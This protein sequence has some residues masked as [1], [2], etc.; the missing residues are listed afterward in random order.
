[1][2]LD[3]EARG[4]TPV[5]LKVAPGKHQLVVVGE[6]QKVLKREV[7]VKAGGRLALALELARLPSE[8]SGHAGL[9]VRCRTQ[10]ELRI[11]VD[12]VDTG[13]SC[14]NDERI[15]IAPG[16][17]KIGLYSPRSDTTHEV[18]HDVVDASYSTRVYVKF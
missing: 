16:T 13:L 7:D 15:S 2:F 3:G 9:K 8:L 11:L 1:V 10:G 14:P 18:D 12:G 5:E 6:H 4:T 17:H